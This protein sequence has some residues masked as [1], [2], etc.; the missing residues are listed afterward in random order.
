MIGSTC[1]LA[2]IPV[3]AMSVLALS[4]PGMSCL[5]GRPMGAAL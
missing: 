1:G 4:V 3:S 5:I 2:L